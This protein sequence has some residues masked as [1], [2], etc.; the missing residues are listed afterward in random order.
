MMD[1]RHFLALL[2]SAA[3]AQQSRPAAAKK[4]AAQTPPSPAA[5]WPQWHGPNRD[6]ISTE[7]GLLK[8]W[9]SGGPKLL[10]TVK[11]LGSGY[12]SL[13]LKGDRIYV[14]GTRGSDSVVFA[15]D[16]SDGRAIWHARIGPALDQDR[17]GGPRGTPTLDG[18]LIY[19]ISENGDLACIRDKDSFVAWHRN[20]LKDYDGQNPNWHISESPL[21]DGNNVIATPGGSRG[22]IVAFDKKSGKEV[23]AS[24]ELTD[25]AGYASCIIADV[26]GVRTIMNLMSSAG[27]GVRANDGKLL[28]EYEKPANNVA[29]CTTPVYRNNKVFYTSA[30]GTGGGL[31]ALTP[32]DGHI[33]T[34]EVYF[35]RE[36]Q[37][38]HGGV[39][40]LKDHLY[41][42]SAAILTCME[43]ET[44]KV[45]W[46]DRSVGK[47]SLTYADGMLYVL[48][49]SNTMGLVEATPSGYVE[50]GRFNI[51][52]QGRP[53][54]AHPV[55]CDGKLY[56][57]NQSVLSCYDVR[58]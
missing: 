1:R 54:W 56:I 55:V 43:F 53:S 42:S 34:Q 52:D 50:K 4:P 33:K 51:E 15:L 35:N 8:A 9:P 2:P 37:N 28:W 13:A 14:Q 45:A 58:A 16:R 57:R 44:G 21:I 19:A 25:T 20:M 17:G 40:L 11:T 30:Y 12:G 39:I 41:G 36:M 10:W 18:E 48:S 46:K 23:W 31:L 29:N 32:Q 3:L 27:V 6:N 49:E 24:R 22:G 5:D 7:T 38:H 26:G 47:G